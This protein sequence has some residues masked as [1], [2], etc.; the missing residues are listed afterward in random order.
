MALLLVAACDALQ[1]GRLPGLGDDS[2]DA[3]PGADAP[4]DRDDDDPDEDD[5]DPADADEGDLIDAYIYG[6]GTPWLPAEEAHSEDGGPPQTSGDYTCSEIN[7]FETKQYDKVIAFAANSHTLFPGAIVG[8]NT[9]ETGLFVPK[10]LPRAPIN[11]SASLEGVLDGH[12]SATLE[13]PTMS[14]Y[15][16]AMAN[17][18]DGNLI[19]NTPAAITFDV[20]EVYSEEQFGLAVGLDVEWMSGEISASFDWNETETK[21]RF[22]IN[23]MQTYYT[24]DMDV[25]STPSDYFDDDVTL[26][27]AQ[28][29]FRTDPPAYVA[30]VSYGRM[31]Y[32][33]VNS[34]FSS[35]EVRAALEWGFDTGTVDISGSV[36]LTHSEVLQESQI[37]AFVLGGNGDVA[38]ETINGAEGL[39][40]FI[41]SGGS[42][43]HESL[44]APIAYKLHYLADNTPARFALTTDYT[45]TECERIKQNVRVA[46]KRIEVDGAGGDG[47]SLEIYGQVDV[48]DEDNT[49]WPL[50][51]RSHH[52]SVHI[53]G[54]DQWPQGGAEEIGS[55]IIPMEPQPG[56]WFAIVA[57]VW[58]R[59]SGGSDDPLL[60]QSILRPFEDGWRASEW[61]IPIAH[62]HQK[63]NLVI[64]LK[65]VP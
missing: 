12:L 58:D 63:G 27:D 31:V 33:T 49:L 59:D 14:A 29:I 45:Y 23:F 10:V 52:Q 16:E 46:L 44:G 15:R 50:F 35:E 62:G 32:F 55:W 30:S 38:V 9:I 48:Q 6:L 25:P 56:H 19:G 24:V 64:E 18:L 53:V 4:G 43:S 5:G 11:I 57:N 7:F 65:P 61:S 8:G 20:E 17:I 13:E 34:Q 51:D 36:S 40:N 26:E 39:R 22:G 47:T 1:D 2:V 41:L 21:S 60:V 3:A 54:G 28:Q 42:F 37:N